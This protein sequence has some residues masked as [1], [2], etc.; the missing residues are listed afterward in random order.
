MLILPAFLWLLLSLVAIAVDVCMFFLLIRLILTRRN[1]D[2]LRG[3]DDAGRTLVNAVTARTGRL[4]YRVVRKK[5]SH[6]G[7]LLVSLVALLFTWL[8]LLE[9]ARLL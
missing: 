1:I 5:L 7:E 8:V 9:I 2:R 6:Q 4:W 3:F